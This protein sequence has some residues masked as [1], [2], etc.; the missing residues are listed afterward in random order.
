MDPRTVH[1]EAG[2]RPREVHVAG[3]G[4][5]CTVGHRSSRDE[6]CGLGSPPGSREGCSREEVHHVGRNRRRTCHPGAG[7][8]GGLGNPR[9]S[10]SGRGREWACLV[11][12][13]VP[14]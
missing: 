4:A 13:G 2:S 10:E 6:D 11:G 14:Y 8:V 1:A 9:E 7:M 3:A 12:S 5:T